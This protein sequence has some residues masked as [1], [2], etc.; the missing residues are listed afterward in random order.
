MEEIEIISTSTSSDVWFIVRSDQVRHRVIVPRELLDDHAGSHASVSDRKL[1][2]EDNIE[3]IVEAFQDR[4]HGRNVI[5][6]F[7]SITFE[8]I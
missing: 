6:I 4:L 3:A 5:G 2:V 7:S 8:E 1:W